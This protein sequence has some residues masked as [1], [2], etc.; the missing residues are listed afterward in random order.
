MNGRRVLASL[1][2]LVF[3]AGL[4][5]S[6]APASAIAAKPL[7]KPSYVALGDS[8][9]VGL[10]ATFNYGYVPRYRDWLVDNR[11]PQGVDLNNLGVSGWTSTDLLNALRTDDSMRRA[12]RGAEVITIDIGGNDLLDCNYDEAKLATALELYRSNWPAILAEVRSLNASAMLLVMDIYNPYP[13]GDWRRPLGDGWIPQFNQVIYDSLAMYG[14]AGCAE[15]YL[16]FQGHE[17]EYTYIDEWDDIHPNNTG[18][19]VIAD[20]FGLVTP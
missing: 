10:W 9:A 14:V 15:V 4:V 1:V 8:L 19:Q 16:A 12:V 11:Y 7:P 17:A 3:V 20:C 13:E 6:V 2:V 5:L 18:H